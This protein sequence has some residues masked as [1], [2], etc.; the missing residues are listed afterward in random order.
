[1]AGTRRQ[2]G[3]SPQSYT[4]HIKLEIQIPDIDGEPLRGEVLTFDDLKNDLINVTTSKGLYNPV[5]RFQLNFTRRRAYNGLRWDE[6]IPPYSLA[7]IKM[8]RSPLEAEQAIMLGLTTTQMENE[9]KGTAVFTEQGSAIGSDIGTVLNDFKL[10]WL[11]QSFGVA[12]DAFIGLKDRLAGYILDPELLT[13]NQPGSA[14]I[15]AI[16]DEYL[17]SLNLRLVA[18]SSDDISGVSTVRDLIRYN[19]AHFVNFDDDAVYPVPVAFLQDGS[20][21]KILAAY[22]DRSFQEMF[23]DTDPSGEFAE[24]VYRP[25]PFATGDEILIETGTE[26]VGIPVLTGEQDTLFSQDAMDETLRSGRA[27]VQTISADDSDVITWNVSRGATDIYNLFWVLPQHSFLTEQEFKAIVPPEIIDHPSHP[28]NLNRFGLRPMEVRTPYVPVPIGDLEDESKAEENRDRLIPIFQRW[29]AILRSWYGNNSLLYSGKLVMKGR[30]GYRVGDRLLARRTG[31]GLFEFY[32]E[33][34]DQSFHIK[35]GRFLSNLK[36]TRGFK[37]GTNLAGLMADLPPD[38]L[39]VES[40]LEP[41]TT[42]PRIG[43]YSPG[44]IGGRL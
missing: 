25:K 6:L 44:G 43:R 35:T 9:E 29:Q 21:W 34:V 38:D 26:D 2:S 23:L 30:A 12:S 8:W 40:P 31:R 10:Y 16:L 4:N 22:A 19:P 7:R 42:V 18:S 13:E 5:G 1:M 24:F 14:I 20:L 15:G 28:S 3:H 39:R 11:L 36:V 41:R 17:G 27:R 32:I 37:S 33:G